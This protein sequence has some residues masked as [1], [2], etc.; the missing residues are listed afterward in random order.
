MQIQQ[1]KSLK[2]P[3]VLLNF[4]WLP[5]QDTQ[6]MINYY[7]LKEYALLLNP[8]QGSFLLEVHFDSTLHFVAPSPA[9]HRWQGMGQQKNI[10]EI[11]MAK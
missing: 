5:L 2:E 10:P 1:T 4:S 3:D 11:D 8:F 7:T 9:L 6:R